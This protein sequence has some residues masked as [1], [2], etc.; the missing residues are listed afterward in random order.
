MATAV[1][2][3]DTY[4]KGVIIPERLYTFQAFEKLTGI[5]RA[6]LREARKQGLEVK[7]FGRQ[8]YVLGKTIIDFIL[9]NGKSS[10]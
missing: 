2:S 6:G 8:G 10:R 4:D 7:Y 5:G 1:K 9:T 3:G